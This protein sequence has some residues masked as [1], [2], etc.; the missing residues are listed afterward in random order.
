MTTTCWY[1]IKKTINNHST[2]GTN[3]EYC[4]YTKVTGLDNDGTKS[5]KLDIKFCG[6]AVSQEALLYMYSRVLLI[7]LGVL[8]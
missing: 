4:G 3:V 8:Y 1:K 6:K 2:E 7:V 5:I